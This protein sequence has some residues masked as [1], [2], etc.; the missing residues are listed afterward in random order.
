MKYHSAHLRTIVLT[1]ILMGFFGLYSNAMAITFD[2][3]ETLIPHVEERNDDTKQ[4]SNKDNEKPA[5]SD[6]KKDD[7]ENDDKEDVTKNVNQRN[8]NVPVQ[9]PNYDATIQNIL[10]EK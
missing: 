8:M 1:L 3:P 9:D 4:K 6:D 2:I 10:N 5:K 7:D